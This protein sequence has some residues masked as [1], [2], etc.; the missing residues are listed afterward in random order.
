MTDC[1]VL[2]N[3]HCHL[4]NQR[5][6]QQEIK[7]ET[8]AGSVAFREKNKCR[9]CGCCSLEATLQQLGGTGG[10]CQCFVAN[11]GGVDGAAG[12]VAYCI[13]AC[14]GGRQ[15]GMSC[16]GLLPTIWVQRRVMLT[17]SVA[18]PPYVSIITEVRLSH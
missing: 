7:T 13:T 16:S 17:V 12:S 10:A 1:L 5:Q 4:R 2:L 8:K 9:V 3:G 6:T 14:W 18:S 11:T 15:P